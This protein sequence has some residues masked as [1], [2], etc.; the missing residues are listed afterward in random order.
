MPDSAARTGS[1]LRFVAIVGLT[2]AAVYL[3]YGL[4]RAVDAVEPVA[5]QVEALTAQVVATRQTLEPLV[6]AMPAALETFERAQGRIPEILTE[7]QQYRAVVPEILEVAVAIRE[8]V[9]EALTAV[10]GLQERADILQQEL[11][12]ILNLSGEAVATVRATDASLRQGLELVPE[13][14]AESRAVRDTIPPSL[15]RLDALLAG[16]STASKSAGRGVWRGFVRGVLSTPLDLLRD[17]EE[18]LLRRVV[19][20]GNA[21]TDDFDAINEVAAE[22]LEETGDTGE[23]ERSWVNPNTGNGG[24]VELHDRFERDGRE[25]RRLD[26][27]L[28]PKDGETEGFGKDVCRDARGNWEVIGTTR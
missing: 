12:R 17:A 11:P 6:E 14:L 21:S 27:V 2:L 26:V 4:H 19:Y 22:L 9:P 20:D 1:L 18:A 13:I 23:T 10:A 16:A 24:S 8:Q 3:G 5:L 15:D 25:C 28:R 7:L